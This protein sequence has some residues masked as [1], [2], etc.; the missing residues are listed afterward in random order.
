[1]PPLR[2]RK[3][4]IPLLA[5][6]FLEKA[7]QEG[8]VTEGISREALAVMMDYTWPGNVRELQSAIRFALV[9]SKGRLIKSEHLPIDMMKNMSVQPT[10][11]PSSKLSSDSVKTALAQT[12]GNKSKAAKVLGVG[13][14]TLYR[15]LSENQLG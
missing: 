2:N 9:K 3:N 1:M 8:Q 11:G 13:R 5:E 4:D 15:F 14:A 10:R 12:G 6:T 7:A